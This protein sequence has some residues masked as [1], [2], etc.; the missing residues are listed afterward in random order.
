MIEVGGDDDVELGEEGGG[1][2]E[3]GL[4]VDDDG[5]AGVEALDGGGCGFCALRESVFVGICG[6][7]CRLT[8]CP[9]CSSE[10]KN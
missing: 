8:F 10:M 5:D 9:T 1:F 4:G 3:D 6:S 7:V 2:V